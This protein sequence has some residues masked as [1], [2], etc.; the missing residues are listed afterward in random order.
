MESLRTWVKTFEAYGFKDAF[1]WEIHPWPRGPQ[2]TGIMV[3]HLLNVERFWNLAHIILRSVSYFY[4]WYLFPRSHIQRAIDQWN[5]RPSGHKRSSSS[6]IPWRYLNP[7]CANV[8]ICYRKWQRYGLRWSGLPLRHS[9][10]E[11]GR[12]SRQPA[13]FVLC[14]SGSTNHPSA[15]R[16]RGQFLF[17]HENDAIYCNKCSNDD[18]PCWNVS[19]CQCHCDESVHRNSVKM[20]GQ[21][22]VTIASGSCIDNVTITNLLLF[23]IVSGWLG[24]DG[25]IFVY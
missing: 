21:Y 15:D 17:Y 3:S 14:R 20:I 19:G 7:N 13:P 9:T 16:M 1:S 6:L 23:E 18:Q 12:W 4:R 8:C 22:D 24:M 25:M 2:T 5:Q 11:W 10:Y